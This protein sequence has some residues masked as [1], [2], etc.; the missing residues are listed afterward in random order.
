MV[1]SG[2]LQQRRHDVPWS[3]ARKKDLRSELNR[4]LED[5]LA[6]IADGN[7]VNI[8]EWWKVSHGHLHPSRLQSQYHYFEAK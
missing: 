2:F 8:L 1:P 5:E 4:Y 6:N 7:D 3:M